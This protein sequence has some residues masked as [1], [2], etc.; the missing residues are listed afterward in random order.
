MPFTAPLQWLRVYFTRNFSDRTAVL[1]FMQHLDSTLKFRKGLFRMKTQIEA[2]KAPTAFI[3]AAADMAKR[4]A[5]IIKAKPTVMFTEVI[6]GIPSTA[7]ILGGAVMGKDASSGVIDKNNRVFGYDNMF[8]FDGSV[9]S[10]NPGVNPSLTITAIT[11]R[12]MSL[13]D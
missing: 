9:I 4:Y 5:R 6:S 3:P 13:I 1:L 10:A 8:V 11:E 12:G 2:G 7:H